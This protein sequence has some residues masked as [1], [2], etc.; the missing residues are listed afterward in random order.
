MRALT[1]G[2]HPAPVRAFRAAAL[3]LILALTASGAAGGQ[4]GYVT[5]Q[6]G[7]DYGA[8]PLKR[9]LLG[10]DYPFDMMEWDPI[11]HVA[12]AETLDDTA[13]A[14]IDGLTAKKLLGLP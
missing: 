10:T 9:I 4:E 11:A 3:A 13:R 1:G 14:A 8:G 7:P 6:A 2:R 5:V 12:S